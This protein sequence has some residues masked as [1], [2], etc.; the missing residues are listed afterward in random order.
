M[1]LRGKPSKVVKPVFMWTPCY[2]KTSIAYH[3]HSP[4]LRTESRTCPNAFNSV[5]TRSFS[6]MSSWSVSCS[7]GMPFE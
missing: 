4:D 7:F 5:S 6:A 2:N 3:A 1:S